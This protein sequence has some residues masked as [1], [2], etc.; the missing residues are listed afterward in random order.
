MV[1][2]QACFYTDAT[3]EK[4]NMSQRASAKWCNIRTQDFFSPSWIFMVFLLEGAE[5]VKFTIL[6]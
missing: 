4:T 5:S 2:I 3:G 1:P 6:A